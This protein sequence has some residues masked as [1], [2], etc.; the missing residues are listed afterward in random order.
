MM[1]IIL[2]RLGIEEL[3][4]ENI[5]RNIMSVCTQFL[6]EILLFPKIGKGTEILIPHEPFFKSYPDSYSK[7]ERITGSGYLTKLE[8]TQVAL[9]GSF[10]SLKSEA[11]R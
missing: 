8:E 5:V 4:V 7:V 1:K 9:K 2:G 10:K 3:I 11:Q 6:T